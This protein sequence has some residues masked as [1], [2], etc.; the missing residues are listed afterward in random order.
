[1]KTEKNYITPRPRLLIALCWL[2]YAASYVAKL[3]YNANI[4]PIGDAFGVSYKEAGTVSTFFFFAYGIGQVV[5]GFLCRKYNP[6]IVIF[7]CLLGSA[8]VNFAV[9]FITSFEIIK[10]VWLLNGI[11]M[12]FLWTLIIRLLSETLPK[13][14]ISRAI[15][16]MGTTVATGT[17]AV[18][19]ISSLFAAVASYRVVF[20]IAACLVFTSALLWIFLYTPLVVPLKAGREKEAETEKL[21]EKKSPVPSLL[22]LIVT[23]SLFAMANN[24]VKDGLTAWTP[25]ILKALYNTPDWLSILLTLL[26]PMLAI[27]G[28]SVGVA[29]Q[30]RTGNFVGTCTLLFTFSALLTGAVI[31]LL[32]T[33]LLPV[34][35][36][37]FAIVSCLMAGVNNVITSGVPL[38]MR[39]RINSGRLAGVLNGFCYLG[40]TLSLY[41]LGAVADEFNW[42]TVFYTLLAV[43]LAVILAGCIYLAV[44]KIKNRA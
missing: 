27:G 1:M 34:T 39:D 10:Y 37:C 13:R 3:S 22:P 28:V 16:I 33:S 42:Q 20:I 12:S 24:F 25:D 15:V 5:N 17:F 26:L 44:H 36:G 40:S 19:G 32:S 9:P 29:L 4:S 43:M 8:G 11:F 2:I 7:I 38:N 18:Y 31:L 41:I 23:L 30:K 35:V 14:D 6:K 21:S